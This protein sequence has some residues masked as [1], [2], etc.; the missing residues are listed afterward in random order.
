[1]MTVLGCIRDNHDPLMVV[2]AAI[3]C[4]S[5]SWSVVSLF[6]RS[7]TTFGSRRIGWNVLTA[8][9]AGAAIWCTH[10]I[11]M[12]GFDPGVPISF[13]PALT[14]VSLFV[15]IIG[16]TLGFAVAAS[17][18]VVLAPVL[19]GCIAGLAIVVMHYTGMAAYR[20]QGIVSLDMPHVISSIILSAVFAA[21]ALHIAATRRAPGAKHI[22]TGMLVLAI[23]S[24]HFTGIAAFRVEP[25]LVDGSFTNPATFR[26]LAFA[27]AGVAVVI[28]GPGFAIQFIDDHTRAESAEALRNMSSGLIMLSQDGLVRFFNPRVLELLGLQ[29]DHVSI[30][31]P[32][33]R[34]LANVAAATGWNETRMQQIAD[35]HD[36][37]RPRDNAKVEHHFDDGKIIS[38]APHPMPDGGAIITYDDITE[39]REGQKQIAHMAF[40]DVLTGLPNRRSF[41]ENVARLSGRPSF[42]LLMID[43]DRFKAVNDTLGHAVGDMLLIEVARR[44]HDGCSP[45]DLLFRLGGDE[46]A[47]LTERNPAEGRALAANIIAGL[48][49]RF[50]VGEHAIS[51]GASAGLAQWH[52]GDDPERLQQ[53]A[54]LALYK[55]KENGRGRVEIYREGMM[56]EAERQRKFDAD[57]AG[58]I[59]AGQFKLNYQPLYNLPARELSGF[60][61]LLRWH[62]PE[63]GVVPPAEF[64]PM[65][66]QSGAIVEIGA[67]VIE[68][69]CRQAALWPDHLYM[70]INVSPVQLRSMD[71]LRRLTHALNK[72]RLAPRRIEIEITET[73]MVDDNQQ[74]AATLAG[75]RALGVRIAMDDFGTGYSS[76]AHLREFELDRIKIDRSFINTSHTDAGSAAVVR[77]VISMAQDLAIETTGE[78]VE[79]EQQLANLIAIGCGTAQGYLLG[80]PVDAARATEL[81]MGET[82]DN[83]P[84]K[85]MS[86]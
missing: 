20:V 85:A 8:I 63:R 45:T 35:S 26:S 50:M 55:A 10:F 44:M 37:R 27:V 86:G 22:A 59:K 76:L 81:V 34:Y 1:M 60:E 2:F 53:M 17:R 57:L 79:D 31:M 70:S 61:A 23:V 82:P 42:L 52:L 24:M 16:A 68:E 30:G 36:P 77:A 51:I 18:R 49:R 19:G 84:L 75:L 3:I 83:V 28:F 73:A 25:M 43:L 64:I 15:A 12:L 13:D 47:I 71:I 72:Y 5:G 46:F 69:A 4:I 40:H 58:A 6:D 14:V 67:W 29:P 48:S 62:H 41:V 56:E 74:I 21:I 39:A 11:A 80:R 33:S 9:A 38:I 32:V 54:D 66:E 7:L 65:A 78:G